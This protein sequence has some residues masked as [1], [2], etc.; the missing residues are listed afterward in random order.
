M[1]YWSPSVLI[2]M[3]STLTLLLQVYR[4]VY[5]KDIQVLGLCQYEIGLPYSSVICTL[6]YL[7][8]A[9]PSSV[10]NA[11]RVNRRHFDVNLSAYCSTP[12]IGELKKLP[13]YTLV[14]HR[15][16]T[17]NRSFGQNRD[18]SAYLFWHDEISSFFG[19]WWIGSWRVIHFNILTGCV[20][21]SDECL[22]TKSSFLISQYRCKF[23]FSYFVIV[24]HGSLK[25]GKSP[26]TLVTIRT[27]VYKLTTDILTFC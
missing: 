20:H 13:S 18:R 15:F 2:S 1:W 7:T 17:C 10:T 21:G 16:P 11:L 6:L 4:S 26:F 19:I 12:K 14:V 27:I 5:F 22:P 24:R 23:C 8:W 3:P 9:M 25:T